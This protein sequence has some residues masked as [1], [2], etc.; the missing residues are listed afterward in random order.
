MSSSSSIGLGADWWLLK[1]ASPWGGLCGSH[2]TSCV[3]LCGAMLFVSPHSSCPVAP[4]VFLTFLCSFSLRHRR[5]SPSPGH[6]E[7]A[8]NLPFFAE[9][10]IYLA[11][12]RRT[13]VLDLYFIFISFSIFL[14]D[15]SIIW[16]EFYFKPCHSKWM[17]D[18]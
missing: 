18:L 12:C 6:T 2:T 9:C 16:D 13:N 15:R 4:S 11:I 14:R 7:A 3:F 10:Q 17:R 5:L 8:V 1:V